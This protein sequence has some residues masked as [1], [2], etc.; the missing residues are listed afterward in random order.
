[1]V[2]FTSDLHFG[3]ANIIKTCNRPY[4]NVSEMNE[5]LIQ[6]WNKVVHKDDTVYILGDVS[7]RCKKPEAC[8]LISRLKGHKIL[9]RGNHDLKGLEGVFD[10]EY[11]YYE[12]KGYMKRPIIL[13]HYPLLSWNQSNHGSLHLHGHQHNKPEYNLQMK[14]EGIFRYDVG[15]DTNNYTPISLKQIQS[16]LMNDLWIH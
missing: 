11:D 15:V 4:N 1:M 5:A 10:A 2:F 12:L 14:S 16:F 9:I 6:N 7:F 13:M 3:H 8:E